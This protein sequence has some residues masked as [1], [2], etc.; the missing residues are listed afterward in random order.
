[1]ADEI[2]AKRIKKSDGVNM[3]TCQAPVNIAIIKYCKWD[4]INLQ[5]AFRCWKN[6]ILISCKTKT[7][8]TE[9][10][11]KFYVAGGKRNEQLILPLNSSLS[12]TLDKKEVT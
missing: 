8:K 3:V 1:M 11:K 12:V 5:I 4:I 10:W 9:M 6:S 7:I 2:C